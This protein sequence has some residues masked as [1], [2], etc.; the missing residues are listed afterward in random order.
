MSEVDVVKIGLTALNDV[1]A[2]LNVQLD[3]SVAG[4]SEAKSTMKDY[5]DVIKLAEK[6]I[7]A[8]Q[9]AEVRDNE[10]I[11]AKKAELQSLKT[12]RE[13]QALAVK[14][15]TKAVNE[16][17]K[18]LEQANILD[19]AKAGSQQALKAELFLTDKAI[20]QLTTSEL[21][22]SEAGQALI[23]SSKN[24]TEEL[25]DNEEATAKFSRNVG[26]Y[27]KVVDLASASLGDM[28]KELMEL[29]KTSF[30][31]K[32]SAEIMEIKQR[33]GDLADTMGDLKSE[34]KVLGGPGIGAIVSGLK[35][36]TAGVEGVVASLNLMGVENE[37]VKD[38]SDKMT[39]LI[40][41]TQALSEWEDLIN[42]G[43]AKAIALKIK[44]IALT[45]WDTTVRWAQ[46]AATSA[47]TGAQWLLNVAMSMNPIGLVVIA[48]V[49]LIAGFWLLVEAAGSVTEALLWIVDP[50]GQI[51]KLVDEES[52]AN[53]ESAKQKEKQIQLAKEEVK[54]A[55]ERV[56][57]QKKVIESMESEL[58]TMRARGATE[59]ELFKKSQAI[60][61]AKIKLAKEEAS[62]AEANFKLAIKQGGQIL[63]NAQAYIDAKN[64]QNE[65]EKAKQKEIKDKE[66]AEEK[67]RVEKARDA[68]K[69]AAQKRL[70]EIKKNG[71]REL[72]YKKRIADLSIAIMENGKQKE[73]EA[74]R[75]AHERE[76]EEIKGNGEN[77]VKLRTDLET[78][79]QIERK[80]IEKQYA[81]ASKTE[82]VNDE[83]EKNNLKKNT[84]QTF[85]QE[86][87]ETNVKILN[88]QMNQELVGVEVGSE[89]EKNIREK[90]RQD[91]AN[92]VTEWNK[93]NFDSEMAFID[94]SVATK[95]VKEEEG[96][97]L[98]F[99]VMT[100]YKEEGKISV[101]EFDAFKADYDQ[102]EIDRKKTLEDTKKKLTEDAVT[103]AMGVMDM[104]DKSGKASAL[105]AIAYDTGKAIAGLVASAN[106]NP[107][108]G[109]TFGIAGIIQYAMGALQIASNIKKAIGIINAKKPDTG[110]LSSGGGGGSAGASVASA[111]SNVTTDFFNKYNQ[112]AGVA[113]NN[114]AP[115][116]GAVQTNAMAQALKGVTLQVGVTDI[117]NGLKGAELRDSRIS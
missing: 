61:D 97:K 22:N 66:D 17:N 102:R 30:G 19:N 91:N 93:N 94:Q 6:E 74:L 89:K 81:D 14:E 76:L 65:A 20:N 40:G 10:A 111:T 116:Q 34:M 26:N 78:Q 28:R 25:K 60:F 73:L 109:V 33:M 112:G 27:P 70:D 101:A 107:T 29:K 106:S 57:A 96:E 87:L 2:N 63:A 5:N 8:L 31:G 58:D 85:S 21:K 49:A 105:T 9:K 88:D 86:W 55:E 117:Q 79:Y 114:L 37:V 41:V 100:R 13:A 24:L 39:S 68:A 110:G 36:V 43:K 103:V 11:M 47:V 51:I 104:F 69:D 35:G 16:N 52:E 113:S 84:L 23:T 46:V 1:I 50:V 42:S 12:E 18:M 115:S 54:Q 38:L 71:E 48:V 45:I 62:L 99:D 90:Y 15:Q 108:N 82:A 83:I 4:L 77:A 95:V 7:E 53:K 92:L 56:K 80:K 44:D 32:T 59:A 67:A 98:K 72:D 3:K 75:I 64:K